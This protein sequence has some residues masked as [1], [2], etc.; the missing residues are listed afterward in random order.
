MEFKSLD[1]VS[2]QLNVAINAY[3]DRMDMNNRDRELL[4]DII[5]FAYD[6]GKIRGKEE[7]I[8]GEETKQN[9]NGEN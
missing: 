2:P 1:Y 4:Y 8:L 7:I 5:G 6:E 3:V 9:N